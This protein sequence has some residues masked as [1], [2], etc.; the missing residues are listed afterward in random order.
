MMKPEECEK[1]SLLLSTYL[2]RNLTGTQEEVHIRRRAQ[3]LNELLTNPAFRRFTQFLGGSIGEGLCIQGSDKD[4]MM[5]DNTVSVMYP[6]QY[7][8]Q[9]MKQKTILYMRDGDFRPGYVSLELRQ[10]GQ[11]SSPIFFNSLVEKE[12]SV[13]ISS[14][15]YREQYVS[16]NCT[17]SY[18]GYE[19]NGPSSTTKAIG[20]LDSVYCFPCNTWP[21]EAREW[22]TRPRL[23]GW[24]CQTLIDKIVQC[25]CHLVPV[26]DKCSEDT[27]LQWRISFATAERSLVHSFSHVQLKVYGLLKYFLKQIKGTLK[28]TIGD[29]DILCSYFLKTI[30]FHAIENTCQMFWQNKNL[31]YCF[32]HC[33]SILIGWVKAGFCPNYFIPA[34]NLFRRKVQG[35]H[36]QILLDILNQYSA[37]KWMCL[38]V[39]TYYKPIWLD[40]SDP[41]WQTH[42]ECPTPVWEV[43]KRLDEETCQNFPVALEL[44]DR[45]IITIRKAMKLLSTSQ[46]D[47]DEFYC[48]HYVLKALQKLATNQVLPDQKFVLDNK[49]RYRNIRKCKHWI[50]LNASM[51]TDLLYLA[52]F[53]FLTGN[54]RKSLEMCKQIM[55]LASYY[56]ASN[57][58]G[59]SKLREMYKEE[60]LYL[61]HTKDRL[62]KIFRRELIFRHKRMSLP[63][64]CLE[65]SHEKCLPIA[66]PP[67]P[68]ALFLNF[69]CCYELGDARGSEAALRDLINIQYDDKQGGQK[70]WMVHTL[71]GICYQILGDYQAAIWAYWESSL[72][73]AVLH[74][75]NPAID[76]IAVVYLCMFVLQRSDMG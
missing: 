39:G 17:L 7:I 72:S 19:S 24:P 58:S 41:S 20:E 38:S 25:G 1:M 48:Y 50:I 49:K 51:G 14:D 5:I 61:M 54:V 18:L 56:G 65:L 8:P 69:L 2:D 23:H 36:Q 30:L 44:E 21:K 76:R 35:Q 3:F 53:H 6:D 73:T 74:E 43:Y 52:T 70:F 22:I 33:F 10:I 4:Q 60:Q 42:L 16:K 68:Y 64:F 67:L 59:N 66:I 32:W 34:N 62:R 55:K 57:I 28:D 47:F 13:F 63:H 12:T 26:G 46:A 37:M 40:L 9:N 29:D 71:L 15:I 11:Q 75:W 27:F 45:T 31:F